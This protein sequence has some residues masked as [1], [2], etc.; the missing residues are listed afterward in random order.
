MQ[1]TNSSDVLSKRKRKLK[2]L[3][4]T[5]SIYYKQ[6]IIPHL[7][8]RI[9]AMLPP[10]SYAH[11]HYAPLNSFA[12]QAAHGMNSASFDIEANIRDGDE[13]SGLDE[14]GARE[15]LEIMKRERVT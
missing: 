10:S 7:P 15:V 3:G 12:D 13:R 1:G 2:Q 8:S 14:R 11:L 4:F 6:H 9:R 5:V